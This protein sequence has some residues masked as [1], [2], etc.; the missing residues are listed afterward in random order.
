MA[1]SLPSGVDAARVEEIARQVLERAEFKDIALPDPWRFRP[2]EI[3]SSVGWVLLVVAGILLA[4]AVFYLV[5]LVRRRLGHAGDGA[6]VRT[7][8]GAVDEPR[9]SAE[10]L[11]RAESNAAQGAFLEA[12]RFLHLAILLRLNEQNLLRFHDSMTNG[13]CAR[14]LRND[15]RRRQTYRRLANRCDG[16]VFGGIPATRETWN[17]SQADYAE[18]TRE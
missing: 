7:P 2:P 1:E 12:V 18:C 6:S 17:D 9:T 10:A 11:A 14:A 8:S 4:V 16:V 15:S 3:S 13:E 5:R